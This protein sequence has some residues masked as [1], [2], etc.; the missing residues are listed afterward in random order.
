VLDFGPVGAPGR[1]VVIACA[2][3]LA[4]TPAARAF[5]PAALVATPDLKVRVSQLSIP[6][7]LQSGKPVSIGVRY[8]VRGPARKTAMATV[9]FQLNSKTNRYEV[10][11]LPAKVRPAIWRWDVKDTLPQL[12]AG[13]YTAIATVTLTRAGKTLFTTKRSLTVTVS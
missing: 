11:S 4:L 10:A 2:A 8:I 9:R 1:S 13:K 6:S 7:K 5:A 12:G 3:A